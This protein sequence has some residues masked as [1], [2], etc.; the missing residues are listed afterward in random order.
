MSWRYCFQYRN[1]AN[2]HGGWV[3]HY[4]LYEAP[5]RD[6]LTLHALAFGFSHGETDIWE[7]NYL[8]LLA[9]RSRRLCL[10]S[11]CRH[12]S[13]KSA[14]MW[15]TAWIRAAANKNELPRS[16]PSLR[17]LPFVDDHVVRS[18]NVPGYTC[19][20]CGRNENDQGIMQW[21]SVYLILFRLT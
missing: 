7:L 13:S 10:E 19:R 9:F 16:G 3:R 21:D 18:G 1:Q 20:C 5:S 2:S 4:F 17:E 6:W 15:A 11:C 12:C 14:C 8:Q